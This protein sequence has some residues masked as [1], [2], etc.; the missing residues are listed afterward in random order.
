[1]SGGAPADTGLQGASTPAPAREPLPTPYSAGSL[2]PVNP[3]LADIRVLRKGQHLSFQSEEKKHFQRVCKMIG[4]DPLYS[5]GVF[6]G[7]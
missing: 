5:A 2:A 4:K 7:R 1:M 3:S 6:P